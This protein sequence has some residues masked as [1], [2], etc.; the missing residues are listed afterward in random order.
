[1]NMHMKIARASA[2]LTVAALLGAAVAAAQPVDGSADGQQWLRA[3]EIRSEA[4]NAQHGVGER[5]SPGSETDPFAACGTVG[6]PLGP[7]RFLCYRSAANLANELR[8]LPRPPTRPIVID[9][10]GFDWTDAGVGFG[11]A[12]GLGLLG[13]GSA[14]ALRRRRVG[15]LRL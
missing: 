4:L 2:A 5:P 11:A 14:V 1:M 6:A 13:A 9:G 7:E 12:A 3:L 8:S 15:A 10:A